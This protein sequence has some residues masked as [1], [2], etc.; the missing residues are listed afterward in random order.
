[1]H[2]QQYVGLLS[3]AGVAS[4]QVLVGRFRVFESRNGE[5][6]IDLFLLEV[7]QMSGMKHSKSSWN[8]EKHSKT[9]TPLL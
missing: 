9:A 2:I 6:I 3:A 7:F 8:I 1:M 4:R 5:Y